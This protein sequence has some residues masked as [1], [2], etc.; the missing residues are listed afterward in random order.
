MAENMDRKSKLE[1]L[2]LKGDDLQLRM[3]LQRNQ[4]AIWNRLNN[5]ENRLKTSEN[6]GA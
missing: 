5:L 6:K 2:P 1:E 4:D 3:A